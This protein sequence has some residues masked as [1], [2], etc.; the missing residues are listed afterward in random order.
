MAKI[1]MNSFRAGVRTIP[2]GSPDN[3][4]IEIGDRTLGVG[5]S[6]GCLAL[7]QIFE[8]SNNL[9]SYGDR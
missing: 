5:F 7:I 3:W 1:S 6:R 2:S 9:R 4:R 8:F